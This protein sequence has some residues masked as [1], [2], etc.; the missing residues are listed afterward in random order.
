MARYRVMGIL[1]DRTALDGLMAQLQQAQ[2][3]PDDIGVLYASEQTVEA[4]KDRTDVAAGAAAGVTAGS[5][6][7][8]VAG[9]MSFAIPGIGPALGAGILGSTVAGAAAGGVL[10]A[11][12]QIGLGNDLAASYEQSLKD[13]ETILAI[14][15]DNADQAGAVETLLRERNIELVNTFQI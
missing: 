2:V 13:G 12:S 11:F 15:N 3:K 10:G 1:T 4:E 8:V 7:G 9:L 14:D 6:V 5:V